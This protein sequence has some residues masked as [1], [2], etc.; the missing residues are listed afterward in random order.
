MQYGN[1]SYDVA[2]WNYITPFLLAIIISH[3]L[4][5][6]RKCANLF[7][8]KNCNQAINFLIS[9]TKIWDGS[10]EHKNICINWWVR[11]YLQFNTRNCLI[12][13]L[14]RADLLSCV[15]SLSQM[16]PG[17]H[18][19]LWRGWRHET[20]LTPPVEY[21]YLSFQ[22]GTSFGDHLYN[23]RAYPSVHCSLV[24]TCW[25]RVDLFALVWDL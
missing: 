23:L 19:N 2:A 20:G 15:L 14:D 24:V 9:Q 1:L 7:V 21:F 25:E 18:Q 8:I 3:V 17:P 4:K 13:C 12:F 11:K 10:F 5:P 16:C 22:G 6:S